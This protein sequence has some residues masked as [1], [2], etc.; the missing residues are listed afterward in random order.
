MRLLKLFRVTA[1]VF[2]LLLCTVHDTTAGEPKVA[3]SAGE[4]CPILVGSN[5][6]DLTLSTYRGT[7][8]DLTSAVRSQPTVLVVYRGGWCPY[9]TSQLAGLRKVMPELEPLG[10]QLIAIS[11]DRPS[12]LR[13]TIEEQD[14]SYILLSDSAQVASKALGLAF[15]V[16]RGTRTRYKGFG[17]DLHEASGMEHNILPVPAVFVLDM[18][19]VV[20]FSYVNP[21][22]RIRLDPAMLLA[23]L[24]SVNRRDEQAK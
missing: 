2:L 16:D 1:A 4:I 18:E 14:L 5:I 24:E 12:K 17:I 23:A 22:Y 13:G 11:A 15:E 10:Y 8:F 3:P 7:P 9:C 21:D 19:G 20:R 6:P